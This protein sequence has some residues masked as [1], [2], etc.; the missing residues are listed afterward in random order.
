[1]RSVVAI[2]YEA[3][4]PELWCDESSIFHQAS[5]S[6]EIEEHPRSHLAGTLVRVAIVGESKAVPSFGDSCSISFQKVGAM[7]Q[8]DGLFQRGISP[9]RLR[10]NSGTF[11]HRDVKDW[12]TSF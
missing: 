11:L 2:V 6:R 10:S 3:Q 12:D 4:T 9:T 7:S 8:C 1:M 5:L